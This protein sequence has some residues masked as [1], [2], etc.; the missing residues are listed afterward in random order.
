MKDQLRFSRI[1]GSS[2]YLA[3]VTGP[4]IL[5]HMSKLSQFVSKPRDEYWSM[6]VLDYDNFLILF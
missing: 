2:M 6:L 3:S 4:N 5:F 1:I